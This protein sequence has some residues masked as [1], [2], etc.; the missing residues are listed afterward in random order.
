[1]PQTSRDERVKVNNK[2]CKKRAASSK[3]KTARARHSLT[4]SVGGKSTGSARDTV[5]RQKDKRKQQRLGERDEENY[6]SILGKKPRKKRKVDVARRSAS[7]KNL[8]NEKPSHSTK[9]VTDSL[10]QDELDT[11]THEKQISDDVT[12]PFDFK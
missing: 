2:T 8:R 10:L 7:C 9:H 3:K 11:T 6:Q 5:P 4:S 1:M 12:N